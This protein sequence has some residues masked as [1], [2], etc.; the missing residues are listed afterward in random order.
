MLVAVICSAKKQIVNRIVIQGKYEH[1]QNICRF[2][3]ECSRIINVFK[4]IEMI[5]PCSCEENKLSDKK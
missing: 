4:V 5:I 2:I 1:C 3:S